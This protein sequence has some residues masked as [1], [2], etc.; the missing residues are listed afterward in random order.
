MLS[1]VNVA[2]FAPDRKSS[3]Y[4]HGKA[5]ISR[6]NFTVKASETKVDIFCVDS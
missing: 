5:S 3:R 6:M 1:Y 4:L 2:Y